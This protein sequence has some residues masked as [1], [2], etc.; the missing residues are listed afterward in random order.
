MVENVFHIAKGLKYFKN[1]HFER[2]GRVNTGQLQGQIPGF[3]IFAEN[4]LN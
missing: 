1:L 3:K 2:E 4:K